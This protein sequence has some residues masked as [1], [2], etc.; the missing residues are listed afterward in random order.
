MNVAF[1][2]GG[3]PSLSETFILNQITGLL[4]QGVGVEIFAQF[5]PNDRKIHRD[6]DRYGLDRKVSYFPKIPANRIIRLLKGLWLFF[7]H[8][9]ENPG[10]IIRCLDVWTFGRDALSL[11]ILY[12][13]IPLLN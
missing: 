7:S 4:A 13:N 3:F 1:V 9:L 12:Y 5:N 10:R 6:V 11:K 8:F 2:V